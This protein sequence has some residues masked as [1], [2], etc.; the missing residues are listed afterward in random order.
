MTTNNK[1][2][3][4]AKEKSPY[5]LQQSVQSGELVPMVG[6]SFCQS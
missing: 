5:I 4:L 6:R 2:N 3:R 1:L